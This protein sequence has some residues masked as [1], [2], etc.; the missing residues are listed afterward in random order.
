MLRA[1]IHLSL[2][3]GLCAIGALYGVGLAT[4]GSWSIHS[5]IPIG[6]A[7]L[8][9]VYGLA[10]GPLRERYDLG[11]AVEWEQWAAFVTGCAVL[12]LALTGPIHDLSDSYLFTA[13]MVQ[14]LILV[15][16]VPPLLLI[17]TPAWL[18]RVILRPRWLKQI[19]RTLGS[20]LIAFLIF[21]FTLAIWHLPL[22]YN[23]T[24]LRMETHI[25]EHLLFIATAMIGW[26]PVLAPAKE[27]RSQIA[28]QL[29]Y[30]LLLPFP[31]KVIGIFIT[32][33]DTVLYPT[34]AIAPRIW[35]IDPLLDQQ[36]GGII[37][38][39]PAGL[40]FWITLA[41][42]FFRWYAESQKQEGYE[43]KIVPLTEER[44]T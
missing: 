15:L 14:H 1:T 41:A 8:L 16:L 26:W 18:V 2:P 34:Y 3:V 24:L 31:M 9:G 29:I 37:M 43:T 23:A 20:A 44:V 38:W 33:S 42:H 22:L 25:L 17:G 39:V 36:I 6:I 32:L 10:A 4:L 21:S 7:C 40:V 12:F 5:S 11:P 27:L 35:G 28:V 19:V 13:H 30:L